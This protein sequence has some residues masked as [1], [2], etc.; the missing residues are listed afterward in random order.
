MNVVVA[1][2]VLVSGLH[3]VVTRGPT[4]PV[5]EVGVPCS[6][7]AVGVLLVFSRNGTVAARVR[8]VSGGRY[9]VRLRPGDYTVQTAPAPKI[10]SGMRPRSVHVPRGA[11]ARVNFFID[12][13]IR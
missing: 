12:T 10:G 9:S 6:A 4:K 1:L 8:T 13:G 3:G 7:P 11:L 5:C 2:A